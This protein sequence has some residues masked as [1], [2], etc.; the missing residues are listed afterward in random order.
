MNI[1]ISA[2]SQN[3]GKWEDVEKLRGLLPPLFI[4]KLKVKFLY[5]ID[6]EDYFYIIEDLPFHKYHLFNETVE[7]FKKEN[8]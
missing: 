2:I 4:T 6:W 8:V 5:E 7:D 3:G 1:I